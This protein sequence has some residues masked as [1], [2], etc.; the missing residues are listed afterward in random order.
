MVYVKNAEVPSI[1]C[2]KLLIDEGS[3]INFLNKEGDSII[4]QAAKR[5]N[6][7]IETI[8]LLLQIGADAKIIFKNG[9][10]ALMRYVA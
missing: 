5:K 9:Q 8:Q 2:F 6:L 1:E 4:I 10:N 3:D 7:Q